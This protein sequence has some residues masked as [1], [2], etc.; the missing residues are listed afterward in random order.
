M[1]KGY[2]I[3]GIVGAS[4]AAII[5]GFL[6]YKIYSRIDPM[7]Q[8]MCK[9]IKELGRIDEY[10][11]QSFADKFNKITFI[12]HEESRKYMEKILKDEITERRTLLK[13]NKLEKY[14]SLTEK[15]ILDENKSDEKFAQ[16]GLNYAGLHPDKLNRIL[17]RSRTL[18]YLVHEGQAK[19]EASFFPPKNEIPDWID[20]SKAIEI[21][22]YVCNLAKEE[23][24]L[25]AF[26]DNLE[27][28]CHKMEDIEYA[29]M[30]F[31]QF[32]QKILSDT[33]FNKFG[34]DALQYNAV[35]KKYNV[36][37]DENVM[38]SLQKQP[39]LDD[40]KV[41]SAKK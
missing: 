12:S 35:M 5:G 20:K 9:Q 4:A 38:K 15:H 29:S 33:I 25:Q 1:K 18:R 40:I 39:K 37:K 36:E 3:G 41:F 30:I 7:F 11:L 6:A 27:K 17:S 13:N 10:D 26:F 22:L 28:H 14:F 23:P 34:I 31:N 21:F 8:E 32:E 19:M 16:N 2:A 24:Q